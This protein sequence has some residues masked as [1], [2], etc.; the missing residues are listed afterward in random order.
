MHE[1]LQNN[2]SRKVYTNLSCQLE[3]EKDEVEDGPL[4]LR[5]TI[6]PDKAL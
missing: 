1:T 5:A 3:W 2:R 6:V 4:E